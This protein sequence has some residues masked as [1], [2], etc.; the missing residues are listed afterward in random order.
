M[1]IELEDLADLGACL[2]KIGSNPSR[3][4]QRRAHP[5]DGQ[6]TARLFRGA[7]DYLSSVERAK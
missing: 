4:A 2:R 5:E 6:G 1:K 3:R 7:L